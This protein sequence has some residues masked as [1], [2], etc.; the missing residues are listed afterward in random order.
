[1]VAISPFV[2]EVLFRGYLFRL[3]YES[4]RLP[5]WLAVTV[6]AV[7][8]GAVHAFQISSSGGIL[9]VGEE[10]LI[11][12]LAGAFLAWLY[13]V[14]GFNLWIAYFVHFFM[15]FW[16][17][18]FGI[19]DIAI[20]PFAPSVLRIFTVALAITLTIYLRFTGS[21]PVVRKPSG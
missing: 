2:E 21:I 10:I 7:A 13:K 16:W 9:R 3:L 5:F 8:F 17:L 15:N 11:T 4:T 20:G 6:S 12:G 18:E 14:W 19:S 1:M